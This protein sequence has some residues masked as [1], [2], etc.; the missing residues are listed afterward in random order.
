MVRTKK[1]IK[2]IRERIMRN[3]ARPGRSIAKEF[4]TDTKTIRN[5]IKTDFGMKAY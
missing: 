4:G 1:F 3:P 5:L 2:V